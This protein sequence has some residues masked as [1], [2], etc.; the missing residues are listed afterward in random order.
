MSD[1]ERLR[2]WRLILGEDSKGTRVNLNANDQAADH[3]QRRADV[4]QW[5]APERRIEGV[6]QSGTIAQHGVGGH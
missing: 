1:Q 5:A 4:E 2:R 3:Q 6:Q